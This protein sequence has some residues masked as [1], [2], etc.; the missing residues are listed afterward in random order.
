MLVNAHLFYV[1][2]RAIH[3][4]HLT[5]SKDLNFFSPES[6]HISLLYNNNWYGMQYPTTK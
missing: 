3:G 1:S 5:T 6:M 2:V 4:G